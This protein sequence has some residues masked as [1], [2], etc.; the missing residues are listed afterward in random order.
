MANTIQ[1]S[2]YNWLVKKSSTK[3]GPGPN[4]YSDK[5]IKLINDNLKL[6]VIQQSGNAF[7]SELFL[8][9]PLGYG[10]YVFQL[11][12]RIDLLRDDLVLGLFTYDD[13]HPPHFGEIDIEFSRWGNPTNMNSQFVIQ[14]HNCR[15]NKYRFET[16]LNGDFSTH[17]FEWSPD[18]IQFYSIHGHDGFERE[19]SNLIQSW[20]YT[21]NGIPHPAEERVHINLWKTY[22]KRCGSQPGRISYAIVNR[23]LF[24]PF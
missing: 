22:E 4:L 17:I 13:N 1:F 11:S 9:K 15:G 20:I 19:N 24:E 3:V 12:S 10:K 7:C 16:K 21:G 18:S 6:E 8:D 14:P 23:F 5:G 2:G